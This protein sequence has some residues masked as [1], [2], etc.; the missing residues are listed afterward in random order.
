MKFKSE[1]KII[2]TLTYFRE[3]VKS[4]ETNPVR[5]DPSNIP[6]SGQNVKLWLP[7]YIAQNAF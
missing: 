6:V 7:A 5:G 2:M 1:I 4:H 3:K